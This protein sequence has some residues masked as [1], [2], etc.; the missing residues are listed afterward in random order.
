MA[1]EIV[2]SAVAQ[3]AVNQVLSRFKDRCEQNS[4][5]KDRIER[6]EMAHIKLEA[7]LETSNKWNITTSAPLLRLQSKL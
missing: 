4:E 3:E 2:T 1:V 5:A 7:A 6:M